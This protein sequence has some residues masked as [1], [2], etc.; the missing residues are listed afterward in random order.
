MGS[1]AALSEL[2][3]SEIFADSPKNQ[4]RGERPE[5]VN[6]NVGSDASILARKGGME[7]DKLLHSEMNLSKSMPELSVP[8]Y[9]HAHIILVLELCPKKR[10]GGKKNLRT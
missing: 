10:E 1:N 3:L 5:V 8:L 9:E 2:F 7:K 6:I 4:K